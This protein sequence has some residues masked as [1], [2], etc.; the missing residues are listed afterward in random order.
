MTTDMGARVG[1]IGYQMDIY[2][3]LEVIDAEAAMVE[4]QGAACDEVDLRSGFVRG[5]HLLRSDCK[6]DEA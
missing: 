5:M 6:K 4:R 1:N 2:E 3:C